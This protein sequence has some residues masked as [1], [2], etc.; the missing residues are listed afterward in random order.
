MDQPKLERMLRLMKLLAGNTGLSVDDL[1]SMLDTTYRSIYRY[2]DTFREAGFGIVKIR[3]GVYQIAT[4]SRSCPDLSRLV[5]FSAEEA[6]IVNH[7]IESLDNTNSLKRNLHD[8]LA[9]IYEFAPVTDFVDKHINGINVEQLSDAIRSER[10]VILRD[11]GSSHSKVTRDRFI[12]PF[13]FTSNYVHV[14][15][16]DLEDGRCKI[17][18]I[19]RIKEVEVLDQP[20]QHADE[21]VMEELD[22]FRM[23][24]R[25][26]I[27]VRLV[28][29]TMARN[30]LLEEYP[31]AERSLEKTAN[32]WVLDT[33][34]HSLKGVGRFV[35]GLADDIE[36]VDSPELK[37]YISLFADKY[38]KNQYHA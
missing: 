38:L 26:S 25:D 21:H 2:L 33:H 4:L 28:L 15:A 29:G 30:L 10:Q 3:S 17:F 14:W 5:Y 32:G 27:H 24:G 31:L 36:I 35:M 22:L 8:K 9:A 20:W 12:E 1:A 6:A 16:Y 11:Y 7:L 18:G 23:P 34:V 37:E 13:G 19:S